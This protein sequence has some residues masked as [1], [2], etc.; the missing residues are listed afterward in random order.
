MLEGYRILVVEDEAFLAMD[1]EDGLLD[2]GAEVIGP[3]GSVETALALL[4]AAL[5]DAAVLDGNLSGVWSTPIADT[6][7]R[8][9]VPFVLVTGY[10]RRHFDH[11]AMRSAPILSKPAAIG[12]LVRE[13]LRVLSR[14]R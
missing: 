8:S 10:E 1:V 11:P 3:V 4:S 7:H 13:L 12:D 6:L 5:P 2:H 14:K 9:N